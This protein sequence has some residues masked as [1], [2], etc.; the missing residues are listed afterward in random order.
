MSTFHAYCARCGRPI[1]GDCIP[2]LC[3]PCGRAQVTR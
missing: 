3:V 1:A 2:V